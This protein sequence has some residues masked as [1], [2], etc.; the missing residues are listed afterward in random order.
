MGYSKINNEEVYEKM[1]Q[2][3][4]S[5]KS[6][7]ISLKGLVSSLITGLTTIPFSIF[8]YWLINEKQMYFVAGLVGLFIFVWYLFF[9]GFISNKLWKW[10]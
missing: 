7:L 10:N 8:S 6:V 9:W 4:F 5:G 2:R 3:L 1:K